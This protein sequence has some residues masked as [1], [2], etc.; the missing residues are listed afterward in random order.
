MISKLLKDNDVKRVKELLSDSSK[1]I[2]T[3]HVRPDGDAIGSAL[4][5]YHVIRSLGKDVHIVTPDIPPKTLSFL[6]GFKSILPFSKYPEYT[7]KLISEADLIICTDFNKISR[8][9]LLGEIIENTSCPK[10]LIDHHQYPEYFA[11]VTFSF[12]EMSS[13]SEL[14]FRLIAALELCCEMDKESATALATGIITD[15]RNLSVNCDDPE[16]YIIMYELIKKG[17]DKKHIIREALEVKSEN[18]FKLYAYAIYNKLALL[19]KHSAAIITL[20]KEELEKFHYERG[21]TEGLV[22][23]PLSIKGITSSFFLREDPGNIR[24]SA[25]SVNNFPV[26]AICEECFNG[27][28]HIQAAGGEFNGSLEECQQKIIEALPLYDKYLKKY[29]HE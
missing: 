17:A 23:V 7:R 9:D 20:T 4:G 11:D 26:S 29:N 2:I 5:L 12:P 15:T 13:A 25:R 1:I 28:G 8:L 19:P 21:D 14:T 3:C 10:I 22:N 6:P 27:G 24:I 18:S 16:I